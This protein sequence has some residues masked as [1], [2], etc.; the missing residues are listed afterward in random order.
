M[1]VF[2]VRL[3]RSTMLAF[4]SSLCVPTWSTPCSFSN[5]CN[6]RFKNSVPLSVCN[7][8]GAHLPSNCVKAATNEAADWFFSGTHQTSFENTWIFYQP[9]AASSRRGTWL[10]TWWSPVWSAPVLGP[11]LFLAFKNYL[12]H[13]VQSQIRLFAD[14]CLL[15]RPNCDI[16]DSVACRETCHPLSHGQRR[17]VYASILRSAISSQLKNNPDHSSTSLMGVF[18]NTYPITLTLE[19]SSPSL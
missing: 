19:S 16:S 2:R 1:R 8:F 6:G 4:V 3:N 5:F 17:G 9:H 15:Y 12:P 10:A 7:V 18:S 13:H 14:D 11:L